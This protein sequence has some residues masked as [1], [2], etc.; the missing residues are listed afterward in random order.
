MA[1]SRPNCIILKVKCKFWLLGRV[2]F[3]FD[4][5]QFREALGK[6]FF[7]AIFGR[8]V[9]LGPDKFLGQMFLGGVGAGTVVVVLVAVSVAELFPDFGHG[10]SESHEERG[11]FLSV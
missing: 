9:N 5:V 1:E 2:T 6:L 4:G 8:F 7:P 3:V 10:V 11:A